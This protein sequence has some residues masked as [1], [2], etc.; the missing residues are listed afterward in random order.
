MVPQDQHSPADGGATPSS[1]AG[2]RTPAARMRRR[3]SCP[4]I[5]PRTPPKRI[6][7]KSITGGRCDYV[8]RDGS[9]CSHWQAI[10]GR[11][12]PCH[13]DAYEGRFDGGEV[14]RSPRKP[15]SAGNPKKSVAVEMSS[16]LTSP[17][18]EWDI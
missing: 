8:G 11:A 10:D 3:R 7:K 12:C 17:K 13:A 15:C 18:S 5:T 4:K 16:E 9:L 14:S 1:S 6:S 2:E